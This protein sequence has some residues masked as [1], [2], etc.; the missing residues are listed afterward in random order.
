MIDEEKELDVPSSEEPQEA[1]E[2]SE[3]GDTPAEDASSEA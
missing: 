2:A 3:E 1:P